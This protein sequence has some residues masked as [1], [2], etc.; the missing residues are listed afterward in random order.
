MNNKTASQQTA[1]VNC[2]FCKPGIPVILENE[3]AFAKIDKHPVSEGHT[4]IIPRRHF[5]DYFDAT[6]EEKAALTDLIDKAKLYLD[7]KFQPDGYNL[8]VNIG[9]AA[10][11]SVMHLHIHLIPRY[12]GDNEDPTGGVRGVIPEK[13]SYR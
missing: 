4:L 12:F 2:V 3:L 8:G 7:K 10:G 13:K 5:A 9:K 11:Q 6:S 1:P